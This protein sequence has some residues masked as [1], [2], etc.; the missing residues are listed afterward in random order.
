MKI[1][2]NDPLWIEGYSPVD[3]S[4]H[5]YSENK[6]YEATV[7]MAREIP[8]NYSIA[9]TINDIAELKKGLQEEIDRV[10]SYCLPNGRSTYFREALALLAERGKAAFNRIFNEEK[11]KKNIRVLL[12]KNATIQ[13]IS[14]DFFLP[15]ELLYDGPLGDKVSTEF[16]WGMRYIISRLIILKGGC[17]PGAS[18]S[19]VIQASHRPRVGLA[20]CDNL[21][22]VAKNEIPAFKDFLKQ[23]QIHLKILPSLNANRR[24]EELKSFAEFLCQNLQIFHMACHAYAETYPSESYFHIADEF[25]IKIYDFQAREFELTYNPLVIL[26]ACRTDVTS[27]LYTSDWIREFLERGAR[28]VL[29]TEFH[30]PDEFAATFITAFYNQL[31]AGKP[32]GKSLLQIRRLFWKNHHNPLGLGYALYSSPDIRIKK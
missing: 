28:G 16:F 2:T 1:K 17:C 21:E 29:A 14:K 6:Q 9:L 25:P 24:D 15:W 19:P 26:N 18:R 20:S 31:L 11:L 23:R 10:A 30:V 4:I 27:P 5:L 32:I 8:Q 7:Q 12:K 3:V 22:G 13:I